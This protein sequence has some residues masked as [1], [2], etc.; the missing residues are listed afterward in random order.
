M[1]PWH[2][3]ICALA[4]LGACASSSGPREYLDEKTAATI[5]VVSKPMVFAHERPELA[6]HSREYVTLAAA[7][8]NHG[9]AVDYY[10]FVYFWSTVDRRAAPASPVTSDE[11]IIAADDRHIR[12]QVFGHSPQEAGVGGAIGAPPGN[13]WTLHIYR[14][15][16]GTLHFLSEA[17]QI[18]VTTPSSEGPTTYELWSDQRGSLRALV[19]RLEGQD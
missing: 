12:P 3:V 13:R 9:G 4:V 8:V 18:A 2:V 14:S 10:L 7:A 15:D 11:L 19:R 17:R 1:L 6:A 5:S 16:L